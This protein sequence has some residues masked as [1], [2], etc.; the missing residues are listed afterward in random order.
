[1]SNKSDYR[2]KLLKTKLLNYVTS[3]VE[4]FNKVHP[5]TKAKFKVE[6]QEYLIDDY[7]STFVEDVTDIKNA[8]E[9]DKSG[10]TLDKLWNGSYNYNIEENDGN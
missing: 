2:R 5:E 7:L 10:K 4:D 1:M 8:Y 6:E 9:S 3:F